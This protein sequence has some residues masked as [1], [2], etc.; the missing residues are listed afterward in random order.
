MYTYLP[1]K[2]LKMATAMLAKAG[3]KPEDARQ[4]AEVVIQ[5]DLSGVDSHGL[6]R[7]SMY[8]RR[9]RQRAVNLDPQIKVLSETDSMMVVDC[10]N[11]LGIATVP[12]VL[13][14]AMDK[15]EKSG[16]VACT[17]RHSNHYGVGN[18]YA[19]KAVKRNMISLL[20]TSTTPCMAP[21]GGSEVLIGTNPITVGVPT[22]QDKP[23]MLDMASTNVAMG[24]LQAMLRENKKIPFDWA[25]TRDGRPTDDPAEAV[26]GSLL[27]IAGYKGYGLAVIVDVLAALL[28]GGAVGP[29]I[30]RLDQPDSVK[31][32]GIGHFLLLLKVDRFVPLAE[33]QARI[34][35]YVSLLK[36]SRKAEGVKEIFLPGE[37][38]MMKM[39]QRSK[40]GITVSPALAEQ[41]LNDARELGLV[42]AGDDFPALVSQTDK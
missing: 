24:K 6:S 8:L 28:A 4:A 11:G 37:I 14:M 2:F 31:A 27:P 12:R 16:L 40:D 21:T 26:L 20:C 13:E 38:E 1:E 33:F 10:D 41:L 3:L 25:I 42:G 17:M 23:V 22:G 5:S 36:N 32:E 9:V 29:E 19:L 34:D 30:G 15:A 7:L 35:A 39:A 18:Y